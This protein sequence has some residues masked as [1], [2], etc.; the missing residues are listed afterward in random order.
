MTQINQNYNMNI[1]P[2]I[3]QNQ[4][5]PRQVQIP[6]YYN[7]STEENINWRDKL[8][9]NPF[10]MVFYEFFLRGT[11]NPIAT[12]GT[13][14]GLSYALDAYSKASGGDYNKSLLKKVANFGDNIQNSNFIQS[15]PSQLILGGFKQAGRGVGKVAKHSSILRAI[16]NTPTMPEWSIV[17]QEMLPHR[18]KV[19]EDFFK[20]VDR[21][22]LADEPKNNSLKNKITSLVES[23]STHAS[24]KDLVVG[25]K[26]KQAIKDYFKVS[27]ISKISEEKAVNF[28]L[29]KQLGK[30]DK[31]I[32]DILD[33]GSQATELTKEEIRKVLGMT[34][35]ELRTAHKAISEGIEKEVIDGVE[36]KYYENVV[37]AAKAGG[38][39]VRIRAGHYGAL[40]PATRPFERIIGCDEI[41]N[42]LWSISGGAK[43][44]T[45]R[46]LAKSMQMFQRGLTFGQGKL[47]LLLLIA[48]SIAEIGK[49]TIKAAPSEK[50][51]TT[52]GGIVDNISWVFTFPAARYIM[53]SIGGI[54]YAGMTKEQV[55]EFRKALKQFNKD[56][57]DGVFKTKAEYKNAKKNIKDKLKVKNQN[58]LIRGIRKLARVLTLDLETFRGYNSGNI[59]TTGIR[60]LPIAFKNIFGVPLRFGLWMAISMFGLEALLSK[61]VKMIFG[62]SYNAEKIEENKENKKEQKQFLKE[63]LRKRLYEIQLNKIKENQ[64]QAAAPIAL[65]KPQTVSRGSI[66]NKGIDM[67]NTNRIDNYTY[68]PSQK[69]VIQKTQA[70]GKR[71][72]YSYIPSQD[73]KINPQDEKNPNKRS[74]VPSQRAANIEKTWD[75]SGL[76]DALR[77]ADLAESKALRILAGNFDGMA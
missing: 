33:K 66:Q 55:N 3:Q 57:R 48:P 42:K 51:G 11:E 15:K 54:R 30:T 43:T 17:K 10:T 6:E 61:G 28:T 36:T 4:R 35:E 59:I 34:K 74:Y 63:D 72:N 39:K 32:K 52:F 71:D 24:L 58:F 19:C 77:R 45:G 21:L 40:G 69:N 26:E 29:L 9:S 56:N 14:L 18:L 49:N 22:H 62:R 44:A 31:E 20:I 12:L 60:N 64:G 76:E 7:V 50:V 16:K 41:Y 1:P 67:I 68:I 53:H 5:A 23:D 25:K 13:W 73:N 46:I 47:G 65:Q 8:K 2:A 70:S 37:K 75:N 27:D 38:K